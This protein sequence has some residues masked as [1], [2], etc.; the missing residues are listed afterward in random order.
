MLRLH[1]EI[2]PPRATKSIWMTSFPPRVPILLSK[3]SFILRRLRPFHLPTSTNAYSPWMIPLSRVSL[4]ILQP[5]LAPI[6]QLL[7]AQHSTPWP[8]HLPSWSDT[9]PLPFK[10]YLKKAPPFPQGN[11][12]PLLKLAPSPH[13]LKP[14]TFH[15][16]SWKAFISQLTSTLRKTKWWFKMCWENW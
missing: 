5:L 2:V 9:S 12:S 7:L 10:V 13:H 8:K 1:W 3:T 11:P 14:A 4:P 6:V 16:L 15:T